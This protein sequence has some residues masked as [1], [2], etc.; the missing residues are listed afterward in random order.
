M[1]RHLLFVFLCS[2]AEKIDLA[3]EKAEYENYIAALPEL[4]TT[5]TSEK[6]QLVVHYVERRHLPTLEPQNRES[7]YRLTET[8]TARALGYHIKIEEKAVF[9]SGEFLKRVAPRFQTRPQRYP[10][11][12]YPIPYFAPD[13]R[14]RVADTV[15]AIFRQEPAERI[16]QYLGRTT[17]KIAAEIFRERLAQIY[18]EPDLAGLPLLGKHNREEEVLFSYGHWSSLLLQESEADFILSNTGI[19]GADTGMPLYVLARAGVTSALVE[20]N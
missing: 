7:L 20:N 14:E 10:A 9:E 5:P 8:L 16:R 4:R 12:A 17:A 13:F 6:I 15:A 1:R 18:A 2:C 19:I 11:L 3:Q